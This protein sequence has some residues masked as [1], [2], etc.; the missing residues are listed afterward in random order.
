MSG[1]PDPDKPG[2]PLN[3][4]KD[5]WHWLADPA[6]TQFYFWHRPVKWIGEIESWLFGGCVTWREMNETGWR[7]LGPCLKPAEADALRAEN[8]RL[9]EAL[10][11]YGQDYDYEKRCSQWDGGAK[12]RAALDPDGQKERR[13]KALAELAEMDADLLD[14]DPEVKP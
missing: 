8:A 4:E 10:T 11:W 14:I 1:W 12:A 3:P 9:R 6:S 2:V 5:G 13:A 7:Y